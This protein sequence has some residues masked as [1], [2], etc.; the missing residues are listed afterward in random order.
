MKKNR[1]FT[2]LLWASLLY[3]VIERSWPS[4]AVVNFATIAMLWEN[5]RILRVEKKWRDNIRSWRR[6]LGGK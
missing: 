1:G 4:I 3:L 5:I 2:W 6:E